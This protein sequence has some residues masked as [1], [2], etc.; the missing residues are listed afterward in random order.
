M[1]NIPFDRDYVYG[2]LNFVLGEAVGHTKEPHIKALMAWLIQPQAAT[3]MERERCT[4]E[5]DRLRRALEVIAVG[6]SKNPI[7]DAA[8][9]LVALGFWRKEAVEAIRSI[10]KSQSNGRSE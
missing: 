10:S 2:Y 3:Q 4:E 8:D 7:E 5:R 9:E 6:D 1:T